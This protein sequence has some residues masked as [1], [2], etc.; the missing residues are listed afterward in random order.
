MSMYVKYDIRHPQSA[1]VQYHLA[2][3]SNDFFLRQVKS[4]DSTVPERAC[5]IN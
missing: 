4:P 5:V 1:M 3:M 2:G